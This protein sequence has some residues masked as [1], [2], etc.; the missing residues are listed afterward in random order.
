MKVF[1]AIGIAVIG[2]GALLGTAQIAE[3]KPGIPPPTDRTGRD[4]ASCINPGNPTGQCWYE[5]WQFQK[6]SVCLESGITGAPLANVATMYRV[7]GIAVYVRFKYG[8]CAEAGFSAAQRIVISY[9]T[10][11]D[12]AGAMNGACAYTQAANYGYLT[13]VYVR[14]NVLGGAA[15]MKTACGDTTDG[16]WQ[17]VFAHEVGHAFGLSHNQPYVSSIMRD[18]VTTSAQDR[19]YLNSLYADNPP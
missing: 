18:G 17:D 8:Q 16:E 10:A 19:L 7:N 6:K 2:I 12:K 9:Y 14:V 5:G 15:G 3:A 1:R 4:S 13:G 11:A